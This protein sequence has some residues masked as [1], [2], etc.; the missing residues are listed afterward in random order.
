[1]I[2]SFSSPTPSREIVW[3]CK[4]HSAENGSV[5][6]TRRCDHYRFQVSYRVICTY[7][8]PLCTVNGYCNIT[9]VTRSRRY[10]EWDERDRLSPRRPTFPKVETIITRCP[11]SPATE[12]WHR[13]RE[14]PP[15]PPA[16][17]A[18]VIIPFRVMGYV[19]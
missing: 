5:M 17:T 14:N 9:A 7:D 2:K 4:L 19:I 3:L 12:Q 16:F 1:M 13:T 11:S 10:D 8:I 18:H 15:R 6:D